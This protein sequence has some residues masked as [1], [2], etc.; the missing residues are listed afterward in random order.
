MI[1]IQKVELLNNNVK[2]ERTE[3]ERKD[4]TKEVMEKVI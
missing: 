2:E 1:P 3:E 4:R